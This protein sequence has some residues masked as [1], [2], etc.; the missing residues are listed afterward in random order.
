MDRLWL[1]GTTEAVLEPDLEICDAHHH[2]WPEGGGRAAYDLED[3]WVD[4]GAGHRVVDTV[5]I[6]CSAAYLEHGP[7][8][9]RPVGETSF[10]ADRAARSADGSGSKIAAIIGHADLTLGDAVQDV[11]SAHIEAAGGRFR[12]V[13]HSGAWDPSPLIPRSHSNPPPR[14]YAQPEFRRGLTALGKLGLSFEA[15]QMHPQLDEVVALARAHPEVTIVVNHLG[16]PMGIGPYAGR[17]AEVLEV[18]RPAMERLVTCPNVVLKLGGIGMARFGAG[19]ETLPQP[20]NSDQLVGFW[21]DQLRWCIDRFGP[22]RCMFESNYPVDAESCS[23]VVLWNAFKKVSAGYGQVE[24]A[25]LFAG[26]AREVYR[27]G[28][29]ARQHRS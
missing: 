6:E 23:Y 14:L 5:F 13:R 8:S 3:L 2:L 27:I 28:S 26:T 25:Q 21:G 15:W 11:L 22:P 20:P 18:W 24:R 4:T 29:A 19:F 10:V 1:A 9:M 12:G 17:R 16:A 7:V